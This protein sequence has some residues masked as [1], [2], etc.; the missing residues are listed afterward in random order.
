MDICKKD[1]SYSFTF[2]IE[3]SVV[4]SSDKSE[5]KET[6]NEVRCMPSRLLLEVTLLSFPE[7]LSSERFPGS[8]G[9]KE[10]AAGEDCLVAPHIRF[11]IEGDTERK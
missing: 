5:D 7:A 11:K 10:G 1:A 8:E 2:Q 4:C 9:D 3:L 6:K